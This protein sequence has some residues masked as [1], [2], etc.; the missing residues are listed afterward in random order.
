MA[1]TNAERQRKYREKRDNDAARRA[2]YLRKKQEKYLQDLASGKRQLVSDL[3]Y[4]SQRY[5]RKQWREQ[6]KRHRE[7][8]KNAPVIL[9]PPHT[10]EPGPSHQQ[11][12]SS[13]RRE[14]S[15]AKC[16]RD[17]EKLKKEL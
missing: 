15:R 7:K 2:E 10:P 6:Q 1:L 14:R 8:I 11:I 3:T 13:K 4:R 5:Q 16:Y 17:N 9:S 12:S